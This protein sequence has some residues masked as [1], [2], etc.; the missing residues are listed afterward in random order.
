[1]RRDL[2]F[3]RAAAA[4]AVVLI[5]GSLAAAEPPRAVPE[6][7]IHA[8]YVALGYDLGDRVIAAEALIGEGWQA[9]PREREALQEIRH[10]LESWERYVVVDRLSQA[11]LLLVVRQGR[12]GSSRIGIGGGGGSGSGAG[13]SGAGVSGASGSRSGFQPAAGGEISSPDDM[14]AVYDTGGAPSTPLW[15][16][17][18]SD[19]LSGEVPL[20]EAFRADVERVA[21]GRKRP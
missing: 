15:R 19:G 8:Q 6:R 5:P 9:T 14:L 10:R 18:A 4:A 20:F 16:G 2:T 11:E 21:A 12:R 17:L 1:M 13:L 7:L 3:A